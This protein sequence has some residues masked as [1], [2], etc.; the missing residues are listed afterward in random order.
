LEIIDDRA[1]AIGGCVN[2]SDS[3]ELL[4]RRT[5]TRAA[6]D[7]NVFFLSGQLPVIVRANGLF[8]SEN[9]W[10]TSEKNGHQTVENPLV[11]RRRGYI[12]SYAWLYFFHHDTWPALSGYRCFSD[13]TRNIPRDLLK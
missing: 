13:E 7:R 5:W 11:H 4:E 3:F 10:A 2:R 9:G 8:S 1:D 12:I 6:V